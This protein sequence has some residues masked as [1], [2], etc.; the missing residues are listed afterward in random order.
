[1]AR[2]YMTVKLQ[3][4]KSNYNLS[5]NHP[6][7]V[8]ALVNN[9]QIFYYFLAPLPSA[10]NSGP[11]S[12]RK[13]SMFPNQLHRKPHFCPVPTTTNQNIPE[14]HPPPLFHYKTFLFPDSL[15][16]SAK[17]RRWWMT[18]VLWQAPFTFGCFFSP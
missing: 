15:W 18:A 13:P 10:S 14:S 11:T 9:C 17:C 12:Q 5:S 8:G 16:V 6:R 3:A 7:M 4:R 2:P 1:M